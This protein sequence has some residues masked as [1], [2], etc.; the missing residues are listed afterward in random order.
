MPFWNDDEDDLFGDVDDDDFGPPRRGPS[1]GGR[2]G[3]RGGFDDLGLDDD[4]RGPAGRGGRGRPMRGGRAPLD[5]PFDGPPRRGAGQRGR[6]PRRLG[7]GSSWD[8][9]F[10]DVWGEPGR[11]G[12]RRGGRGRARPHGMRGGGRGGGFGSYSGGRRETSDSEEVLHFV[13][14]LVGALVLTAVAA[15]LAEHLNGWLAAL[16]LD[17]LAQWFASAAGGGN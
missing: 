15:N 13:Y 17:G 5:D 14:F 7:G 10:G 3:G 8:S 9:G 12:G 1:R 4:S 6:S 2:A 11:G 16:H